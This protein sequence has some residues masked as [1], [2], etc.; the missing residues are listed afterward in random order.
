M[1]CEPMEEYRNAI[2]EEFELRMNN[3]DHK[4]K[5]I[6]MLN[7]AESLTFVIK[8]YDDKNALSK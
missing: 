6:L 1:L 8:R 3:I 2:I 4:P 5:D 7:H